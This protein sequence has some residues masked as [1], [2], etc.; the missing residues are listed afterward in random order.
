MKPYQ[1]STYNLTVA[2]I[3]HGSPPATGTAAL[4]V[5]V[6]D[7][8]DN[9]PSLAA[10]SSSVAENAPAGSFVMQLAA[11]DADA[12]PNAGPFGFALDPPSSLFTLDPRTGIVRTAGVFDREEE[13]EHEIR[14]RVTD[15]G[16][17]P[18]AA[19]YDV[20]IAIVDE[21]DNPS[22]DRS[23]GVVV[24][25]FEGVFPGGAVFAATPADP[26]DP[27]KSEFSCKMVE[28]SENIFQVF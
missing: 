1:V 21:N 23:V 26:D 6:A 7:A 16:S 12:E 13:S 17:P 2:A 14:V 10:T 19:S 3:D 20:R 24:K 11:E 27:D 5:S 15:A 28:G 18:L 8:N 25:T 22:A 4:V 9:A